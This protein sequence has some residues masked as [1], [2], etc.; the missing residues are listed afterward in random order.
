MRKVTFIPGAALAGLLFLAAG[1]AAAQTEVSPTGKGIAGGALLG[2]EAVMLTEAAFGVQPGWAYAVGGLVGA[3][4]GGVGGYFV[5]QTGSA[6]ASMFMLAGG[7]VLVIP[8][9]V[10]VLSATA[11]R[12]PA[13]Y[14]ED[15]G[16]TDAPVADPPEPD[17]AAGTEPGT[18]T[19]ERTPRSSGPRRVRSLRLG[20]RPAL[21]PAV[22]GMDRGLL[23][24]SV[25]A[26]ELHDV[27][28]RQQVAM[29]GLRQQTEVRV[30]VLNVIF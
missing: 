28:T 13:S 19:A 22:V 10:A 11:Y 15:R 4:G 7:M 16:P 12:P 24:L 6:R 3:A 17:A 21:P 14:T 29:F 9:T 27:Y 26:L 5:E 23:T 1:S 25:P 30:P 2:A 18:A 20:K 8:T